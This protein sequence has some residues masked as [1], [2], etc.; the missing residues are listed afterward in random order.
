MLRCPLL[1]DVVRCP[2]GAGPVDCSASAECGPREDRHARVF[3]LLQSPG[4]VHLAE[5]IA[6]DASDFRASEVLALLEHQDVLAGLRQLGRHYSATRARPDNY[7]IDADCGVLGDG[8]VKHGVDVLPAAGSL[9]S[10]LCLLGWRGPIEVYRGP[11]GVAGLPVV[12]RVD[13]RGVATEGLDT[14]EGLEL[15]EG[16]ALRAKDRGLEAHEAVLPLLRRQVG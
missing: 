13:G 6:L 9:G 7:S 2:Q 15:Q 3:R 12:M 16:L 4:I 11:H 14:D 10:G 5:G 1:L 8:A